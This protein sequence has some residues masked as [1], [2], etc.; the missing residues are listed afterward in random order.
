MGK[1]L[2]FYL[3]AGN[4]VFALDAVSRCIVHRRAV[5]RHVAAKITQHAA[6]P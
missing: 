5:L 2:P 3:A 4:V 6:S 1:S